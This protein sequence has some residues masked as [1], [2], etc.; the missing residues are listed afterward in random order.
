M[1][2]IYG[3]PIADSI[4]ANTKTIVQSCKESG[5]VPAMA[6]LLVGSDKPSQTYVRKKSQ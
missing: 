2:K 3:K 1:P 5:V 4:L 6:V